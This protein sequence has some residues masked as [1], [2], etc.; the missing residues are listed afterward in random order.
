[1]NGVTVKAPAKVNLSLNILGK[2]D[3][4]YHQMDM[5]MQTI[6]LYE[7]VIIK[8]SN[9]ITVRCIG[10]EGE[11]IDGIPCDR[12]NTAFKAAMMFFESTDAVGGADIAITKTVPVQAGLGGASSDAAAVLV[13][14]NHLFGNKLSTEKLCKIGC[15]VGA[16]VPFAIMGGTARVTG[17]GDKIKKTANLASCYITVCMP[18]N[19][20]S[21]A[22]GFAK[23]DKL[24]NAGIQP[25]NDLLE[26]LLEQNNLKEF[27]KHQVNVM[28]TSCGNLTT[29]S[30]CDC[31][32]ANGALSAI[33]T[34]SGSAVFGIF[35][36]EA[37]AQAAVKPALNFSSKVFVT[38]PTETGA[39]I[40]MVF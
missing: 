19:G 36:T 17:I 9:G 13:G 40:E 20:V 22:E 11:P 12:H 24:G 39:K 18:D 1:M 14:L 5:I 16:D 10:N 31:L 35:E 7:R 6:S 21:T 26:N 33:M 8:K 23:Y 34:G 37:Q 15:K 29:K 25:D 28:Q 2:L 32:R 3:N 27:C 38:R 30:L 4:G